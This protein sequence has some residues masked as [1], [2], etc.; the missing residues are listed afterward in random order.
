M[1]RIKL[2]LTKREKE[3]HILYA[4]HTREQIAQILNIKEQSVY[5]Y[6]RTIDKKLNYKPIRRPHIL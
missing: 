4:N 3:I 1:E 5:N 2:N 6:L